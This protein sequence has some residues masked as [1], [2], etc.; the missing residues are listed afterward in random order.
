MNPKSDRRSRSATLVAIARLVAIP[1]LLAIATLVAIATLALVGGGGRTAT[2]DE[3]GLSQGS[4]AFR[5]GNYEE[6]A[7]IYESE[8]PS[9]DLLVRRFNAGVARARAGQVEEAA[10][11]LSTERD[12]EWAREKWRGRQR[13][14]WRQHVVSFVIVNIFLTVIDFM[15]SGGSWFYWPLLGWGMG[16]AFHTHAVFFPDPEEMDKGALKILAAKQYERRTG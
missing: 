1:T 2:A 9:D 3:S 5:A 6:A 7:K 12:M 16:L 13:V 15:F 4:D 11:H 8:G 14:E 10:R